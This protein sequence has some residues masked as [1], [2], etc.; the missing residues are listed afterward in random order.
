M[1][2]DPVRVCLTLEAAVFSM[3]RSKENPVKTT[4]TRML[5]VS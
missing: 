2:H 3:I 4:V 1:L 5:A